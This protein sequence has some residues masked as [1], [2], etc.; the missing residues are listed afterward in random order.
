MR[1]TLLLSNGRNRH[2]SSLT[3]LVCINVLDKLLS[4]EMTW[5]MVQANGVE[6]HVEQKKVLRLW[7]CL[8]V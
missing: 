6:H 7:T 3:V 4:K 2:C 8:S 1:Y 5:K